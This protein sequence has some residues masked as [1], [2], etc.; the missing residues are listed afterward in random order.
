MPTWDTR[1]TWQAAHPGQG[2]LHSLWTPGSSPTPRRQAGELIFPSRAEGGVRTVLP[3]GTAPASLRLP[4]P[5]RAGARQP[6]LC[7]SWSPTPPGTTPP[8]LRFPGILPDILPPW[9]ETR[10]LARPGGRQG[11]AQPQSTLRTRAPSGDPVWL[12]TD[13]DGHRLASTWP[14]S[15]R[16]QTAHPRRGWRPWAA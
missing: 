4:S 11:R 8:G 10:P 16:G 1:Q 3:V 7:V 14:L 5:L 12:E 9:P 2:Y 15:L 13:A 6:V